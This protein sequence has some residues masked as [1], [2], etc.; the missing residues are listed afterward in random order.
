MKK[1]YFFDNEKFVIQDFGD[2]PPFTDFLPGIAGL[3]GCPLW[4]FYINRGQ[5]IAG[6]GVSGKELPIMEFSPAE[7]AYAN[8][9]RQGFRT[10]LRINGKPFEPFCVGTKNRTRMEI[11]RSGFTIVESARAYE[12]SVQYFGVP[13]RSYAALGRIVTYTNKTTAPQK[14]ELLDGLA[15]ILPY[16]LCN[17]SFKETGNLFKSW[18]A[19]EGMPEYAFV[20]MRSSTA[21]TAEVRGISGGNF[22]L[23]IGE[24][25]TVVDPQKVFGE[26]RTKTTAAV[27]NK[28]GIDD[29]ALANQRDENEFFCAF[30][31]GEKTVEPNQTLTV[32]SLI[33]YAE[34]VELV[35]TLKKSLTVPVILAMRDEAD[36]E[37][38]RIAAKVETHTA[39]PLFDEYVKQSYFDNVL[40]GGM[41]V[42]AGGKPYYVFSRKHGDP[43]RD[44]NAFHIEPKPY[45]CGNGNF[46]DVVQN[47]RNDP[48]ITPEC[49][50]FNIKYFFSLLQADG[51]N[52]L[53]V[54]GVK[55]VCDKI[56]ERY[57]AHEKL[58]SGKFTVGDVVSTLGIFGDELDEFIK[59]CTPVCE[60]KFGEGYWTDHFV[61][62]I[63]LVTSYLDVYPDKSEDLLYNTDVR[64]FKSGVKVLP[65]ARRCKKTADGAIRRLYSLEKN[66][67]DGWLKAGADDYRTSLAAK[68][69]FLVLIKLATLDPLGIGIDMEGGKPGWCDATNGLP[70][71]F[72]SNVADG[73]ELLRLINTLR[74][75]FVDFV[76]IDWAVEQNDL[77]NAML[78]LLKSKPTDNEFYATSGEIKQAYLDKVYGKGFEGVFAAAEHTDVVK[79]LDL[80]AEKLTDGMERAKALADGWLPTYLTFEVKDYA[81]TD[82][83]YILPTSFEARALP[84]FAEG[85]AKGLAIGDRDSYERAKRSSLYDEKLGLF[86]T[87]EPLDGETLEIG[88][89]RSFPAGWLER[90]SCFL[91]MSY[92]TLLALLEAGMYDEFYAQIKTGLVPF[93]PAE[94]YGRSTLE[95]SSFIVTSNHGDETKHGKGYQ[96]RLTGANAEILS[97][98]RTMMGA[99][100]PFVLGEHGLEFRLEPKLEKSFF[101]DG[102]AS[103]TLF[104]TTKVT[105][106]NNSGRS[107]WDGVKVA[108][109]KLIGKQTIETERVIGEQAEAVR[110]G[111]YSQIEVQLA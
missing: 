59:D 41:P 60:A 91:H 9:P 105:Y 109:Y 51:Y 14:V 102:K 103:F 71:L 61:Y 100:Q 104:G 48:V 44:Y 25:K 23:P 58:L 63:D 92:K 7:I 106:I 55:Y 36:K 76:D 90:E 73:L 62:L 39:Y 12:L 35:Q 17:A 33:G 10:F 52:P 74:K 98:W 4:A 95:N 31:H 28:H 65:R 20:K 2:K 22:F 101:K 3:N 86:K 82:D 99:E 29:S 68:L 85:V 108:R 66:G 5:G 49:G 37:A 77:F 50:D 30:A 75:L 13:N 8:A 83:G 56:P 40:R 16:G 32:C 38:E 47:R 70:A 21:D 34:N 111:K 94:R 93:M 97:M 107:T 1:D 15:Q 45:S 84:H 57:K 69:L 80:A 26:D 89:I 110:N 64:W 81:E 42:S 53:S 79:F 11:K 87:S 78:A 24:Y 54:L 96:A 6:F 88:R 19:A 43:E 46:R 18:M 72:G 27:Y 67:D